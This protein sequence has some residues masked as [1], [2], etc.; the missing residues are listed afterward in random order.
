[1][2]LA[3]RPERPDDAAAITRLHRAAFGRDVEPRIVERLRVDGDL[4]LEQSLVAE[5]DGEIVGHVALSRAGI[6]GRPVLALGPI[7]VRPD[8]QRSGIGAA[9][10]EACLD[11]ARAAGE[12]VVVL[13]GHPTYYPRFGFVPASRL[14]IAPPFDVRDEVFMALELRPGGAGDG[15]RFSYPP[16]FE[17]SVD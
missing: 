7:G 11:R 2:S 4:L 9:L 17:A 3:L 6:D 1:V 16:A 14:G 8:L 10:M 15:G 13:V 5:Q 12:D